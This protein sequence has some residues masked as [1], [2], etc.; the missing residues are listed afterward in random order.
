[1]HVHLGAM[2]NAYPDSIGENMGGMIAFLKRPELK[3]AFRSFYLLPTAF[4]TDLDR[5]FS[6]ISYDLCP[7]LVKVENLEELRKMNIDLTFDFI[8]NHLSVLSP[9]FQDILRRGDQSV[10]RD[11]FIDWNRFWSGCGEIGEDGVIHPG[12]D[13][14][15]A[16]NLR[17]AGLPILMVRLPDGRDV[18]YWNTFYQKVIYPELTVFDV[19]E[20]TGYGYDRAMSLCA[21][22]NART[23]KGIP[24]EEMDWG[25]FEDCREPVLAFLKSHRHY[26][27]QMDLNVQSPLVWE[28]YDQTLEKLSSYGASLIRLD[29]F[30]RV[31]KARGRINF[32]NG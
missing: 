15:L 25:S 8:L 7:S 21:W 29:A 1:M 9:Q 5:G 26:L 2:L 10:Y 31:H 18:P 6:V 17:K 11:F 14:F 16:R 32:M 13:D 4:N 30:T 22:V 23:R 12:A 19:L 24:P 3:D 27:G 20:V 28:W